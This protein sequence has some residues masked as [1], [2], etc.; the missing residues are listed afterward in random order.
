MMIR[1]AILASGVVPA[2]LL[3]TACETS[4]PPK[5]AAPVTTP[6]ELDRTSLP[7]RTPATPVITELDARDAKAPPLFR[8]T[9]PKGAPNV[10]YIL[11]DDMGFGQP[12][13]FG[14]Q[15]PMP[16][17]R[18]ARA[19][20]GL[21]YNQFHT[22]ALCSPTRM[23]ILTGRNHHI[24][25]T[26]ADHGD[27]DRLHRQ[28]RH[29]AAR[30]HAG[31]RDPPAERLQHRRLRQVPRDAALGSERLRLA[32]TAGRRTPASMSSTASSAARRTSSPRCSFARHR[33]RRA[34]AR[35][36]VP[37]HHRPGRP[38]HRLDARAALADARQALLRLLRPRR[39]ARAA[40]GAEGMDR[41]VQ[42]EVRRRAGTTTGE[43]ARPA[44]RDGHRPAGHA[45]R[46]EAA[47]HQGLGPA[48]RRSRRR[49]SPAR[50]R[51]S[52]A[53][54]PRPTT[55]SAASSRALHEMGVAEN[56]LVFY[57]AGDNGAS[58]EGG[59]VG[60]A[61]RDDVLQRRAARRSRTSPSASTT[62]AG[63]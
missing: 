42:G 46:P 43:G 11:I 54:P 51:S 53:S 59:M 24:V 63:R 40:P 2:L 48:D 45:A 39:D 12:S 37:P 6:G 60:H 62:S 44:D 26:G 22:T 15:I 30:D 19:A 32:S 47:G 9:A 21:R 50:W 57:E 52:P 38:R 55:R 41:E 58:A 29:P 17:A 8:V 7:I 3:A 16:I 4:A 23:A 56:T 18:L 20:Q 25:N 14:G 36:Q 10:V 28:H 61:Q 35:P 33:D 13:A 5:A 49:S 31:R 27:R 1:R 34:V